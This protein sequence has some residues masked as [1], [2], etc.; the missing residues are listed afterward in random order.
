MLELNTGFGVKR[1][2]S[3][4]ASPLVAAG[5]VRANRGGAALRPGPDV[6]HLAARVVLKREGMGAG[7]AICCHSH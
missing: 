2:G 1:E 3:G 7:E 6:R 5:T 4:E